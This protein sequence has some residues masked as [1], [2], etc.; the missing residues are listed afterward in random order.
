MENS[1][2]LKLSLDLIRK[3]MQSLSPWAKSMSKHGIFNIRVKVMR[4]LH[5]YKGS[6]G[7]YNRFKEVITNDFLNG[8]S[9]EAALDDDDAYE[10]AQ[11]LCLKVESTARS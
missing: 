8:I 10:L 5:I 6:H 7:D 9:N 4:L 3:L 2:K 11:S 1:N